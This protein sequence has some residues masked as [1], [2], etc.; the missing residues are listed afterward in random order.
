MTGGQWQSLEDP[1]AGHSSGDLPSIT[2]P[3]LRPN[4][5]YM[6]RIAIYEDYSLRTL[7]KST[8]IIEVKT[9]GKSTAQF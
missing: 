6:V 1:E 8:G 4:T 9:E 5:E 2:V 7:G 3:D